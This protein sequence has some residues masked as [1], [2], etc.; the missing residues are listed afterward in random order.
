MVLILVVAGAAVTDGLIG[1]AVLRGMRHVQRIP[2]DAIWPKVYSR[3]LRS[4]VPAMIIAESGSG[5]VSPANEVAMVGRPGNASGEG[6]MT[7]SG[8]HG[9]PQQDN[10]LSLT[11]E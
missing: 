6:S 3:F 5:G 9:A 8:L 11:A 4:L 1:E 10:S 2:T 7:D